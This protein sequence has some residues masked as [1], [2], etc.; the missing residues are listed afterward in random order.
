MR[1]PNKA[2]AY[3]PAWRDAGHMDRAVA[4]IE[5]WCRKQ[6]IPGLRVEVVRLAKRTPLIMMEAPGPGPDTVL[7]YGHLDKQPEMT[8]WRKGLSPWEPVREGDKLYGRGGADDGY[9]SFASLAAL[10]LLREQ[11]VPHAR[12]VALIEAGEKNGP[13]PPPPRPREPTY[14]PRGAPP[15]GRP[16]P[17][18]APF[19]PLWLV[20]PP[21]R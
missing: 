6:P 5:A 2:P 8:G 19:R 14:P 21:G 12:C 3:D 1:S 11:N 15:G 18:P 4:L 17:V 10:R 16:A 7:L 13:P 20:D 9:S